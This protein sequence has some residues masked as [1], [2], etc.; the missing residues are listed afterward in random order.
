[1]V[2]KLLVDNKAD[3]D[4]IDIRGHEGI[5]AIDLLGHYIKTE[6]GGLVW[7]DGVLSQAFRNA[8]HGKKTVLFID[9]MLRIPKRELNILVGALSPDSEDNFTLDTNRAGAVE[10]E[11][12]VAIASSEKIT[13]PKDMLWGIGTTNAGAGYSVDTIDEALADRFRVVIKRMTDIEMQDI[14]YATAKV[15]GMGKKEVAKLM[16][17]YKSFN[18]LRETGELVKL[19]NL[20]H[21]SEVIEFSE[22]ANDMADTM[23]D[24]IPTLCTQDQEGYPNDTQSSI[25]EGLIE[26]EL[27]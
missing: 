12:G 4:A 1:M 3:F 21:L 18:A 10:I 26:K 15:H 27:V 22:D 2:S 17:F 20:R 14:L 7:K 25:I 24:L 5:E 8:S 19:L 9:E 16:K 6:T 11:D 13:I 23:T